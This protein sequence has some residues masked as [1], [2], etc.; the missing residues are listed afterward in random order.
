M[1]DKNVRLGD[2]LEKEEERE[3]LAEHKMEQALDQE[4]DKKD[5]EIMFLKEQLAQEKARLQSYEDK[6]KFWLDGD[7][8][9]FEPEHPFEV[10]IHQDDNDIGSASVGV[11]VNTRKWDIPRG[12]PTRIP[13]YVLQVLQRAVTDAW[14]KVPDPVTDNPKLVHIYKKRFDFVARPIFGE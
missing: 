10:T 11:T 14:V 7:Y 5:E 12:I 3:F 2:D 9:K 6:R 13:L 1:A 8:S 4:N